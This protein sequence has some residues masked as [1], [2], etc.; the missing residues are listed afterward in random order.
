LPRRIRKNLVAAK[1]NI[2]SNLPKI[3]DELAQEFSQISVKLKLLLHKSGEMMIPFQPLNDQKADCF[4]VVLA[5]KKCL[6]QCDIEQMLN[7][8]DKYGHDL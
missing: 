5:G 6:G 7:L 2:K 3:P 1:I 8:M 4:R